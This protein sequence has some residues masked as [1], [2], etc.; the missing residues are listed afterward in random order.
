MHITNQVAQ[1]YETFYGHDK[2]RLMSRPY[3]NPHIKWIGW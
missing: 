1:R 2:R 3:I